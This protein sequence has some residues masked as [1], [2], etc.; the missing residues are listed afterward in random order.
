MLPSIPPV[1]QRT[2]GGEGV[3]VG[4]D[5]GVG[6]GIGLEVGS[7]VGAG[8]GEGVDVSVGID[9]GVGPDK[10][11]A[12]LVAFGIAALVASSASSAS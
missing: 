1:V 2:G 3:I 8:V 7:D 6:D 10:S 12:S 5:V 9:D 11:C 4:G